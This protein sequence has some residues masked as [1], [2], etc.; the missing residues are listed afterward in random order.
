MANTLLSTLYSKSFK[1]MSLT[2]S[3]H[4]GISEYDN[5]WCIIVIENCAEHHQTCCL[6]SGSAGFIA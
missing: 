2:D 6:G 1:I 5:V 3:S 4:L